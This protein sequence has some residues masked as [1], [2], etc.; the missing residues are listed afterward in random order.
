MRQFEMID[1]DHDGYV[2]KEE[3][4]NYMIKLT[5]KGDGKFGGDR[6]YSPEEEADL[7]QRFDELVSELLD[8]MDKGQ[9]QR[10]DIQEFVDH[11]HVEYF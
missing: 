5:G 1:A 3:L 4:I 7:R 6:Q 9:D 8:R 10:V 2:D 11:Y